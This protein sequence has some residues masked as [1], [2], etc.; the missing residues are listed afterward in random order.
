[1]RAVVHA[2]LCVSKLVDDVLPLCLVHQAQCE[3]TVL[4]LVLGTYDCCPTY[5]ALFCEAHGCHETKPQLRALSLCLVRYT[6]RS[7]SAQC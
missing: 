1:M 5:C 6:K 3:C 2:V 7:V 4:S